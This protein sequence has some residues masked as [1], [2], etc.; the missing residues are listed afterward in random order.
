M[1]ADR[2]LLPRPDTGRLVSRRPTD[3]SPL[4]GSDPVPGNPDEIE[5]VAKSGKETMNDSG[6]R[7]WE[8]RAAGQPNED[9]G[10][11]RDLVTDTRGRSRPE[12]SLSAGVDPA[13]EPHHPSRVVLW[14]VASIVA[15][16]AL[17]LIV[18]YALPKDE[19]SSALAPHN[20]RV[21]S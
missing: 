13:N 9:E 14:T 11:Y 18:G 2:A 8:I 16:A 20:A 10:G 5:R 12:R 17:I 6:G 4:T 15:A 7:W 1:G 19:S 3:W 21:R